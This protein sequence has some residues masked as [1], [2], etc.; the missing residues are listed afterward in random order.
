MWL[1]FSDIQRE[2]FELFGEIIKILKL[3][4]VP[5][6]TNTTSERS[7]SALKRLKTSLRSTVSQIWT[8][9][10][11]LHVNENETD[12]LNPQLTVEEF[13]IFEKFPQFTMY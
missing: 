10:L 9:M 3:I 8:N 12:A 11:L 2:K 13:N 6:A 4:F 7:F 1:I 5:P